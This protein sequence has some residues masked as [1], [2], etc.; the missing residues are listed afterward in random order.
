MPK[1]ELSEKDPR[2]DLGKNECF[3]LLMSMLA[4]IIRMAPPASWHQ[5]VTAFGE[6]ARY[7]DADPMKRSDGMCDLTD[8]ECYVVLCG[9]ISALMQLSPIENVKRAV[10]RWAESDVEWQEMKDS[11]TDG[12]MVANA[13]IDAHGKPASRA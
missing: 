6:L 11:F 7:V 13:I 1:I 12:A 8:R 5:L 4:P 3:L 10:Q 2:Q 9:A